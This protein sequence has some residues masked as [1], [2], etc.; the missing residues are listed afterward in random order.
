MEW[1]AGKVPN[2]NAD[3]IRC[4]GA[5]IIRFRQIS[6]VSYVISY[7]G[8]LMFQILVDFSGS[9]FHQLQ[10]DSQAG[11]SVRSRGSL[12]MSLQSRK[13]CL[14]FIGLVRKSTGLSLVLTY[15][16][17]SSNLSTMSRV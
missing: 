5:L 9:R 17:T 10:R 1:Y 4:N 8:A 11:S 14:A 13:M 3:F 7:S 15:G 2:P 6:A 16:T 12:I